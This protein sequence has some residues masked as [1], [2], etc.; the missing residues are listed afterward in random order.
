LL[1]PEKW[2][3]AASQ[4]T[5]LS[6][7]RRY[8]IPVMKREQA[9][10]RHAQLVVEIRRHDRAYYVEARP[11]ISDQEYDRLYH[12][13][14]DLEKDFPELATPDSPSH[15]VGGAPLSEFQSV[16]HAVPMMSLD[17]T[18][19]QEEV[20]DFV[21]R[22]QKLLP[23]E[24]LEWVVEPKVDGV[25]VSLRYEHG[26]FTTGAT[27]GDGTTGDDITA[28]L[29]TIRS[30]PLVLQRRTG[31][32]PAQRTRQREQ[33]E[34]ELFVGFADGDRRDARPTLLEVRGEVFMPL[35]GFE[36]LNAER[37]AAGEELF[38][39]PRNTAAGSL[40]QLDPK[41]VAKRPLDILLYGIGQIQTPNS[42]LRTPNSQNELLD[43][44]K[45]L[46]FKTPE[47]TWFCKS[48]DDLIAAIAE[49]DKVR[50]K[51]AYETDG[52]VIKLNSFEQQRRVGATAKAPRW[53]IAYKYAPEQAETKLNAITIQVGRTGA[54]TPVAEL[55]P[56]FLA[57]SNI[58][59]A[60]LHNED[61]IRE[62]DIRIGDTVVIEK[63]GEVIPA[64]VSVVL[65]KRPQP[66]PPQFDFPRHIEG[67]CPAC[68]GQI[69]RDPEFSVWR[70]QNIAGC[71]TQSVRRVEFM[72]Q[73]R[74]LD[75]EGIGGVVSEKVIERGLVKEPLDLF[76]LTVD[77]LA[78][79]NLGTQDE[80]RIFG[81]K[82]AIKVVEALERAKSFSLARW[83]FA[84]G[85]E[86]AG[87]TT[88]YEVAKFHNDLE[89]VA[90]SPLLKGIA[91]LGSLYDELALVS[92]FVRTNQLKSSEEQARRKQQFENL[93]KEILVL[94]E[95]LAKDGVAK[96]N[97]KWEKLTHEKREKSKAVPEFVTVVGTKVAKNIV[98]F[99]ASKA[100]Q[101]VLSRL[102]RLGINPKTGLKAGE[103]L[104]PSDKLPFDGK[105]FV[106]TGSLAS[107]T[108]DNATDEVRMRGGSVVG[109]VSSN[110]NFVVA[111]E[112]AGSKLD[113]AKEL[114]V[115]ILTEK[116]FLEMLGLKAKSETKDKQTQK[117][118]L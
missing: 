1:R 75:I 6:S 52:A 73:R 118:L 15:R 12:E 13:L 40:K 35:A 78:K 66:E 23:D 65:K 81:E 71:P 14:L 112:E 7:P 76:D 33:K 103:T 69:A 53:A 34:S 58:S 95:E 74:A 48:E 56:V 32:S 47:R 60:T 38:G 5:V 44:L 42:E 92:P 105:T 113:K 102:Q 94:G 64:V 100:G 98:D 70:C 54:L 80:P 110:T 37:K 96:R 107:M 55:E 108:R 20:R 9:K 88:A 10:T 111:G 57:G 115:K 29:K 16:R 106:L 67:K 114:G 117:E 72:A 17:N 21:K 109:S 18:Y 68:G 82:N 104:V 3:L 116:E 97:N 27:R 49:L 85:I 11:V 46:G 63:A 91:K 62:K 86:E 43:F 31:V 93:K 50:K 59:R 28:N 24:K 36:K 8:T 45:S 89:H 4:K 99:F 39:N 79:L 22:V 77:Q 30:V 87:E 26:M 61:Y 25:A 101:K 84:L 19:S 90:N 2:P 51:F 83:L 41:I